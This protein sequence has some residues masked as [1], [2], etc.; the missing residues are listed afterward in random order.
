MIMEDPFEE[1]D[2]RRVERWILWGVHLL[3]YL[4]YL[5]TLATQQT[6]IPRDFGLVVALV[7]LIALLLHGFGVAAAQTHD[8]QIENA[9]TQLRRELYGDSPET[10]P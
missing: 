5:G 2:R 6:L 1:L 10:A 3:V 9:V 8:H 4:A 7:W